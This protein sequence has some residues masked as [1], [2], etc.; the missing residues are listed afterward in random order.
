MKAKKYGANYKHYYRAPKTTQERR[1][2][3]AHGEFVRAK[4][5]ASNLPNTYDDINIDYQKSWKKKRA[6]QY[7]I[8]KRGKRQ[9]FYFDYYVRTWYIEEYLEEHDIPYILEDIKETRQYIRYD[10]VE[11]KWSVTTKYRLV[12][13]TDKDIEF[14]KDA[15]RKVYY[16][17]ILED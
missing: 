8:G 10:G 16:S 4:R 17:W 9:E 13:W 15:F 11:C 6:K 1:M 12:Y 5:R 14:P 3:Y 7:R 2:S